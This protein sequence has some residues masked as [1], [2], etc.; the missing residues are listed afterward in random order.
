MAA[1]G[2]QSQEHQQNGRSQKSGGT[3]DEAGVRACETFGRRETLRAGGLTTERGGAVTDDTCCS[4]QRR[5][6]STGLFDCVVLA[7]RC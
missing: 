2:D 1:G 5:L 4:A 6:Y 7:L 3:D